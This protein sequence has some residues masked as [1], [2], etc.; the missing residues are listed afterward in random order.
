MSRRV[1]PSNTLLSSTRGTP[2][3]TATPPTAVSDIDS[4]APAAGGDGEVV[5]R[6]A[7]ERKQTFT[8]LS[9]KM[10]SGSAVHTRRDY[11][12]K[13]DPWDNAMVNYPTMLAKVSG[14]TLVGDADSDSPSK[15]LLD[16]NEKAL[17]LDIGRRA[18]STPQRGTIARS[19]SIR[20][21]AKSAVSVLGKRTRGAIEAT[22]DAAQDLVRTA[23]LRSRVPKRKAGSPSPSI[24]PASK[25]AKVNS[26]LRKV[27]TPTDPESEEEE[28]DSD[29]EDEESSEPIKPAKKQ[30]MF[31]EHGLYVGQT[32]EDAAPKPKGKKS[33]SR[34]AQDENSVFPLPLFHGDRLINSQPAAPGKSIPWVP[35]TLPFNVLHPLTKKERPKDWKN[36]TRNRFVDDAK[37]IYKNRIKD[38]EALSQC[39]CT[40]ETGGCGSDCLNLTMRYECNA[41]NCSLGPDHCKNRPFAELKWRR[42]N[43]N[44]TRQLSEGE[45]ARKKEANLF[46]EGIEVVKTKGRGYG[47]RA[48]RSFRPGQIIVE[49]T[50]EIITSEE[51]ERRMNKEYKDHENFYMMTFNKGLIIDGF[52][53]N[54]CRFVN[55]SCDPNCTIEKWTVDGQPRMALF[56]GRGGVEVGDEITY[57]YKFAPFSKTN[58]Q[59]CLCGA[60]NCIGVLGPAPKKPDNK[61]KAFVAAAGKLAGKAKRKMMEAFSTNDQPSTP[62]KRRKTGTAAATPS[63][64]HK[65]TDPRTGNAPAVELKSTAVMQVQ[66]QGREERAMRRASST[67][68]LR[69]KTGHSLR[70]RHSVATFSVPQATPPKKRLSLPQSRANKTADSIKKTGSAIA[71]KS[72]A[73]RKSFLGLPE[74]SAKRN[75]STSSTTKLLDNKKSTSSLKQSRISFNGSA[76]S[77]EIPDTPKSTTRIGRLVKPSPKVRD[78][79][80][81]RASSSSTF[82]VPDTP[83]SELRQSSRAV[84]PSPKVVENSLHEKKT[85]SAKKA[86]QKKYGKRASLLSMINTSSKK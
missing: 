3:A 80:A 34:V 8:S 53:G 74:S 13:D 1:S 14:V 4:V 39:Q 72:T 77:L 24:A 38:Q 57:D 62:S 20:Q 85:G 28:A 18:S 49:Y 79:A 51:A 58:V 45:T 7:R 21:S 2:S 71:R 69:N 54:V 12:K 83:T 86:V 65:K 29:S 63:S 46:G 33:A 23:S 42:E 48:M 73:A 32:R 17:D 36:L 75:T 84:K 35:Y 55:H 10:L 37:E 19:R 56:A 15:Q 50:G 22:K 40:E 16:E 47:V 60:K 82:D 61:A 81:R 11:R 9:D 27:S 66:R 26:R 67:T 43:K 70:A 25:K 31:L 6:S 64:R 52:V 30:K 68:S 59:K 76:L 78:N 41:F 44:A 5:R